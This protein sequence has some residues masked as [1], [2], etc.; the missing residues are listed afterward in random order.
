MI[1]AKFLEEQ[2]RITH[3]QA[4]ELKREQEAFIESTAVM[5]K[6]PAEFCEKLSSKDRGP[7]WWLS[8]IRGVVFGLLIEKDSVKVF[9]K[10]SEEDEDSDSE[11]DPYA[12]GKYREEKF[13]S[14]REAVYKF[15]IDG[16]PLS[17]YIGN[18]KAYPILI[19]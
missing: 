2:G 5:P 17:S 7:L 9:E 3:E 13:P 19:G 8:P 18:V 14:L 16:K 10:L 12:S 11:E 1:P 6:T 4:V 15:M